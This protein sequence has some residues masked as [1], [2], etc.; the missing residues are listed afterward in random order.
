MGCSVAAPLLRLD[1]VGEA[2]FEDLESSAV[3]SW[4][5]AAVAGQKLQ[6]TSC[7]V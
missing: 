3:G 2:V 4:V 1:D 5:V 7:E 6:W